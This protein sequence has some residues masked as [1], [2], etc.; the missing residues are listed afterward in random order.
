MYICNSIICN[1]VGYG[2]LAEYAEMFVPMCL[3]TEKLSHIVCTGC[4]HILHMYM[5]VFTGFCE[6]LPHV[7]AYIRTY[8]SSP[9]TSVEYAVQCTYIHMYT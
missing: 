3:S 1:L 4:V 6:A 2:V 8:V 5:P 7:P 9:G